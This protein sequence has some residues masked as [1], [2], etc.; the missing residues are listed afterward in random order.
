MGG[1]STSDIC[2]YC[3]IYAVGGGIWFPTLWLEGNR[4]NLLETSIRLWFCCRSK[5]RFL[6]SSSLV[7]SF[8]NPVWLSVDDPEEPVKGCLGRF[9]PE[10]VT[11]CWR[12]GGLTI[13]WMLSLEAT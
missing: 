9:R 4:R 10:L 2:L 11:Y 13:L 8:T 6:R 12:S 5:F 7:P 1:A 3:C